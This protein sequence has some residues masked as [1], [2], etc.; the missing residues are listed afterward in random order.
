MKTHPPQTKAAK[1][2]PST[3]KTRP[4]S[5]SDGMLPVTTR[6]PARQLRV[7]ECYARHYNVPLIHLLSS[8]AYNQAA[9]LED[10]AFSSLEWLEKF[11]ETTDLEEVC[12]GYCPDAFAVLSR[13]AELLRRPLAAFLCASRRAL[14]FP[15][16][17]HATA[18]AIVED[19]AIAL[20]FFSN[21]VGVLGSVTRT[22]S[23]EA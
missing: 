10:Q 12:L 22:L 18:R 8:E 1:G 21:E 17:S 6:I 14:A 19:G 20:H 5:A 7:F 16:Y 2:L 3:K 13:A 4:A 23:V 9:T 11:H 15:Q